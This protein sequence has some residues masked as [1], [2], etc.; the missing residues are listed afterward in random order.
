MIRLLRAHYKSSITITALP[1]KSSHVCFSGRVNQILDEAW[2]SKKAGVLNDRQG[3]VETAAEI[4]LENI[5]KTA[6]DCSFFP[7]TDAVKEGGWN[8][9]PSSLRTFITSVVAKGKRGDSPSLL[10]VCNSIGQAIVKEVRPQSY[11]SPLQTG[12]SV[13]LHRAYGSRILI[14]LLNSLGVCGSYAE[15][16]QYERTVIEHD[17]AT[18]EGG[19]FLQFAFACIYVYRPVIGG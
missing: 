5:R 19:A 13:Y 9:L 10:R 4:I 8:E 17:P 15:A 3:I 16:T 1:G 7:T 14:D 2:Y 11:V 18:L 12:L 6:Y